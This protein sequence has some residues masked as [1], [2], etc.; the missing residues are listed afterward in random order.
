MTDK[1][2]CPVN[3]QESIHAYIQGRPP[4][5]FLRAV[6]EN[7]LKEAALGADEQ[8]ARHLAD[9]VAFVYWTVPAFAW[10]SPEA[11]SRYLV[12]CREAREAAT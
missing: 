1:A 11:V 4:G 6:L 3:I 10:G 9:I 7:N 5:G 8:N 12:A 2:L